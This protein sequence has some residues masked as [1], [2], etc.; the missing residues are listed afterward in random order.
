MLK[1]T[2]NPLHY[3]SLKILKGVLILFLVGGIYGCKQNQDKDS[4]KLDAPLEDILPRITLIAPAK[5]DSNGEPIEI[6]LANTLSGEGE[7]SIG[8]G[9]T[10][11]FRYSV[12]KQHTVEGSKY[13]FTVVSYNWGGSGTFYYLT[14]IDK[15]TLKSVDEFLLG[16][17]V[18]IKSVA[19][20]HQ[21][22]D[23]VSVSYMDR[24]TETA[25]AA[26]PDKKMEKHLEMDQ[27]K[28]KE[29][30]HEH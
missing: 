28:L 21:N 11:G 24:E 29:V 4:V 22:S 26:T 2:S 16:D 12:F 1:Q 18:E 14:A 8:Q 13:I 27:G 3:M 23:S 25:M 5:K 15:T 17:R 9:E 6:T 7:Y 20:S 30:A 19:L 10:H